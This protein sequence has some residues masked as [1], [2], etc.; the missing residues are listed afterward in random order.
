M[1]K[2]LF[3]FAFIFAGIFSFAQVGIGTETP[4]P[5]SDLTLAST[6]K[7]LLLNKVTLTNTSDAAPLSAH[8]EGMYLY[9]T[10]VTGDVT[11]GVYYNNGAK[12]IKVE[13]TDWKTL[14]NTDGEIA[15]STQALGT[16]YSSGNV[17]GTLGTSDNLVVVSGGKV[18]SILSKD[19]TMNGGG[20]AASSFSWGSGNTVGTKNNTALGSGNTASGDYSASIGSNNNN[21]ATNSISLGLNN[22][23]SGNKNYVIGAN[24]QVTSANGTFNIGHTFVAGSRNTVSSLN[25]VVLGYGN[26]LT[27]VGHVMGT[28]N[29]G[30]GTMIG[31]NNNNSGSAILIGGQNTSNA[32]I[33]R[34]FVIGYGGNVSATNTTVLAN[35][36]HFFNHNS[37]GGITEVGINVTSADI[38]ENIDLTI[39]RAIRIKPQTP[40]ASDPN[41]VNCTI[42]N[43]GTIRYN[44]STRKHEGCGSSNGS[45]ST[46][47]WRALY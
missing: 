31:F 43:E 38:I 1:R 37:A 18:H 34:S 46:L 23:L 8:V 40:I 7:G 35:G 11:E 9:N 44:L 29:I 26:N 28:D 6:N 47:A 25:S 41:Q 20:E 27:S 19:G 32:G 5:D 22:I 42:S 13:G 10:A 45:T 12:W 24:N 39:D 21:T 17:L 33:Q 14:G 15:S 36:Y 30:Q 3:S 16:S 2:E 4:N